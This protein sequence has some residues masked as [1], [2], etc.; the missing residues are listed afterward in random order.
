MLLLMLIEMFVGQQTH[1]VSSPR[2]TE[3]GW[4]CEYVL[5]HYAKGEIDKALVQLRLAES[6]FSP[7]TTLKKLR[8]LIEEDQSEL[9]EKDDTPNRTPDSTEI[10]MSGLKTK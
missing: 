1:Q 7:N 8:A 4:I 9:P 3:L 6:Q 10:K 5:Y 2:Q